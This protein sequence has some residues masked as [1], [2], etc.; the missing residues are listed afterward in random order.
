MS[1]FKKRYAEE[2]QARTKRKKR[3]LT[4]IAWSALT[5][6]VSYFVYVRP[7]AYPEAKRVWL[8]P[9]KLMEFDPE[10]ISGFT[11]S[12]LFLVLDMMIFFFPIFF[13]FMLMVIIL[14][15]WEEEDDRFEK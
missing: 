3:T 13:M 9:P 2:R 6:A 15:V 12:V 11:S 8:P 1:S 14:K 7:L 10:S 5:V 4:A